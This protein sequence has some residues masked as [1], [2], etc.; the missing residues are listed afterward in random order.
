MSS[1][2][3]QPPGGLRIEKWKLRSVKCGMFKLRWCRQQN[4]NLSLTFLYSVSLAKFKHFTY[5]FC[6]EIGGNIMASMPSQENWIQIPIP[7]LVCSVALNKSEL[8]SSAGMGRTGPA[9]A[10]SVAERS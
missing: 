5:E 7:P 9:L 10:A 4:S 8:I 1:T 2:L 6:P 3:G